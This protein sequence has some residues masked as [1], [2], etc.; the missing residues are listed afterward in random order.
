MHTAKQKRNLRIFLITKEVIILSLVASSLILVGLEHFSQLTHEQLLKIEIYE[1][2]VGIL[3]LSEFVFE[4][5]HA[6]DRRYYFKY[7]WFYLFAAI[8]VPLES[9]EL[10]R[11]IRAFRLI[12]ISQAFAHLRY[13]HNTHLFDTSRPRKRV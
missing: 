10:L 13:E 7:H 9:F 3:F 8:P 2:F 1:T 12:K 4:W 5:Y 11:G 6:K